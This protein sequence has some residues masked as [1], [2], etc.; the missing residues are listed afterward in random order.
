M[1]NLKQRSPLALPCHDHSIELPPRL[2]ELPLE[3][4]N[5]FL[6]SLDEP[7][8][9]L[10]LRAL[11]MVDHVHLGELGLPRPDLP[12]DPRDLVLPRADVTLH[13]TQLIPRQLLHLRTRHLSEVGLPRQMLQ[14]NT[15]LSALVLLCLG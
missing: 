1:F 8:V 13:L 14:L 4:L 7:V 5:L 11:D 12:P 9:P 10:Y 15:Q 6:L 2:L 3:L